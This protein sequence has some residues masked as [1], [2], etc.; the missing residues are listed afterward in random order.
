MSFPNEG[1]MG[2][3][4]SGLEGNGTLQVKYKYI[5][6]KLLKMFNQG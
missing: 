1:M 6:H 3:T 4:V 2:K 5:L